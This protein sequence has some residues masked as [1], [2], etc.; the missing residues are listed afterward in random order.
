MPGVGPSPSPGNRGA[1]YARLNGYAGANLLKRVR[2]PLGGSFT[3]SYQRTG[4]TVDM[5]E[6]RFVLTS[7]SLEDGSGETAPGHELLTKYEYEGGKY[8]R[9]ERDF[10]GFATVRRINPDGGR[11]VQTFRNDRVIHKGLLLREET[12]DA[13][14]Q[15]YLATLNTYDEPVPLSLPRAE[16]MAFTPFFLSGTEYCTPS[17]TPLRRVEH[18][19]YE[20]Q[21]TE[22]DSP[23]KASA[24]VMQYDAATGNV[25]LF[26]DL[27]DVADP[28]DDLHA[29]VT[30]ASSPALVALHHQKLVSRLE[31]HAGTVGAPGKLLRQREGFYDERGKLT[32]QLALIAQGRVAEHLLTWN[33]DGMLES[34][35]SPPNARGQRYE[36][37]YVYEPVTRSMVSTVTDSF[38][39]ASHVEHDVRFQEARRTT[40][41]AGNVTERG[42]DAFGRLASVWGPYDVGGST[43]TIAVT[44]DTSARPA[45]AFTR[46]RLEEDGGDGW[47]D[48]VVFVDGLAR[49]IQT[50]KDAEVEGGHIG[51]SVTGHLTFDAMGRVEQKGQ[52]TFDMGPKRN[53]VSGA[54]V[55]PATDTHDLLGRVVRNVA[56]DGATTTVTYDFGT[57]LGTSL[58]Q[59]RATVTDAMGNVRVLYRDVSDRVTAVEEYIEDRRPTT[60]YETDALGQ[61]V[62]M[63]DAAGNVTAYAYDG[64]GRRTSLLHPDTGL[65]ELRYDDANNLVERVDPNLRAAGLSI[66]Y[67]HD[68]HRLT[69]VDHP[70]S[71]DILY[72]YGGPGPSAENTAGR[73]VRMTDEVGTETRGYGR[74]GEVTRTTRTVRAFRPGDRPRTFET[75][76]GFDS[77]GRMQRVLYPDGEEVRYA[78]DAG[79]LLKRAVGYRPGSAHAPP[80]VQVYLRSLEYDHFGQRT[81]LELGNGVRTRYTYEPDTRRLSSLTTRTP[82]GR[83]LQALSYSYDRIGN[84]VG[85]VNALGQPVGRRS[86]SVSYEFGYDALYRLTSARGTALARP[87]LVDRFESRFAYS[88][89]HDMLRHTQVHE[90]VSSRGGQAN[91][92]RPAH[93][94]HDDAY[95]YGGTGPHQATRIGDTLLTYD[96][97]GNTLLECRTVDGSVCAGMG[98]GGPGAPE[99]HNHYRRYVWTERNTLRAVVDGGGNN[100]TRFYYDAEGERVVKLGRGGTSLTLGQFFSIKGKRH[101]TKHIFAGPTRVAS[102]LLPVPDGDIGFESPQGSGT[103]LTSTGEAALL[104]ENGCDPS[105]SQPQKCPVVVVEPPGG[106]SGEPSVRP[107]TYYYHP[108]HL[109]STSWVTD[110][111]SRVHEHVEYFPFG[112]VWRQ[113]RHDDDG[114]PVRAPNYL[115]SAKE[116]DEETGLGYFG[117]RYYDPRKARWISPDPFREEW[118]TQPPPILLSL[119]AY[120]NHAPL[121]WRDPTGKAPEWLHAALDVAGMVPVI[122]EIADGANALIYLSEGRYVEAGI[123]AMGMIPVL[124]EAGKAGKWIAKGVKQGAETVVQKA[125]A[126][127]VRQEFVEQGQK[128]LVKECTGGACTKQCFVAGTLITT[129]EGLRP[130]EE[131]KEGDEVLSRDAETGELGWKPVVRTFVTPEAAVLE[132]TLR[133]EDDTRETLGV[134]PEHPFW[135]EGKGWTEARELEPGSRILTPHEAWLTTE[136]VAE[137]LARTTVYNFE[138][139]DS[140]TYFVGIRQAWVHNSCTPTQPSAGAKSGTVAK[141]PST[142]EPGPYAKESIP[143]HRGKP[144]AAEQRQV[145]ELMEKHGCHTCGTKNPGTKSGNAIAD[146]QPAQALGEPKIFLP[147]CNSCKARQGGEVVQELRRRMPE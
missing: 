43:P 136:S 56:A 93:S 23:G 13:E 14:G 35:T 49:V 50:K 140:H 99:T 40:D 118:G 30:Y 82:R 44:Y 109:G 78:Y 121:G 33:A 144:T 130:I 105:D 53:Y 101:G 119:Y 64:L 17:F 18:R 143:A 88:D 59:M 65:T 55:R 2:R 24:Q 58:A 69:R 146:H 73:V 31:V 100:A 39:Y 95:T 129:R 12:R 145:N 21:T 51:M 76:F 139:A 115:F 110:Q 102:K 15:L 123:S 6:S 66:R 98:Q 147:H 52:T 132:V 32:R 16:C 85:M 89:I 131:V 1:L 135:M 91:A 22:V 104:N 74:L 77:F 38:G 83:V 134:T 8:D 92:A 114:A 37:R 25:T 125:V 116:F 26:E 34:M 81:A 28:T 138:V 68:Y 79:G 67:E 103:V 11:V 111:A 120:G 108:D 142:L 5:P 63:V 80:E 122:G 117:A 4:N 87:G 71:E 141:N 60:R 72:E 42:Y 128:K 48:T 86:G 133:A 62:R 36:V 45:W 61:L 96:A 46:N 97:N 54:P 90:L 10:L 106:T 107:A 137:T 127:E 75:R 9:A 70:L 41:I 47:L 7:A 94:N 113:P 112:E 124:G 29:R 126:K 27:G 20:G 84:I 57:P 19:F 3:L